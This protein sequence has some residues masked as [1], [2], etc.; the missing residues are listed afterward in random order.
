[1]IWYRRINSLFFT[2]TLLAQTT[3]STNRN[4]YAQFYVSDKRLVMIYLINS[5]S[6]FNDTLHCFFKEIVVP[7]Y[8]AMDDHMAQ[9]NNKTEKLCHKVVSTLR[10]LEVGTPWA[11]H[12]ELYIGL[13]KEYIHRDL[14][15]TNAPIVL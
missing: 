13:F 14:R 9:K 6:G 5:Q 8:L 4:K 7:V 12:A 10:I 2:D 11:N 1:M 15:M 3:P